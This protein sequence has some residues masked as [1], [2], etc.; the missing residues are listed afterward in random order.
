VTL[1][2]VNLNTLTEVIGELLEIFVVKPAFNLLPVEVGTLIA[3]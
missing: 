1:G 2:S 3:L